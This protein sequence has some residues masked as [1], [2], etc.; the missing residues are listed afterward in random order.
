MKKYITIISL[1]LLLMLTVIFSGCARPIVLTPPVTRTYDITNFN[2]VDIGNTAEFFQFGNIKNVPCDVDIL[3]SNDYGVSITANENIFPY[4]NVSKSGGTLKIRINRQQIANADVTLK[5][6]ISAPELAGLKGSGID[7][8]AA[9][10][11]SAPE[12]NAT[13]SDASNLDLTLQAGNT[14]LDIS[15]SSHAIIRGTVQDLKVKVSEASSLD[16]AAQARDITYKITSSSRVT[17]KGSA[18]I[19]TAAISEAGSLD[20]DM[21]TES[22]AFVIS[23]SS[24]VSGNLTT[25]ATKM[26]LSEASRV[27]L[28]GSGSSGTLRASSSSHISLLE[29]VLNNASVTLSEASQADLTVTATMDVNLNSSSTLTYHGNP[30]LG[31]VQINEGSE[32]VHSQK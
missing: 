26:N 11:S 9:V 24:H 2:S 4:I 12:F 32:L 10:T 17:D 6:Q 25:G 28:T 14:N 18:R 5:I 23:A 22:A 20:I 1:S 7:M 31:S 27:E 29:F 30:V 3:T 16:M 15:S 21:K 8:T 13:V 19:F